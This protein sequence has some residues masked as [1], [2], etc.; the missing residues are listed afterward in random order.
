MKSTVELLWGRRENVTSVEL[1]ARLLNMCDKV[2]GE[3]KEGQVK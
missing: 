2:V 1:V 3:N